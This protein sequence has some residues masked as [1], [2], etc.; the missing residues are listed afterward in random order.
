VRHER[1]LVVVDEV[2]DQVGG[3]EVGRQPASDRRKVVRSGAARCLEQDMDRVQDIWHQG[4]T[5]DYGRLPDRQV[6]AG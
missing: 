4:L 6:R 1:R 2:E 3:L 5:A